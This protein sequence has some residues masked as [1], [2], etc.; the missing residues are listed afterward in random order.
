MK[1]TILIFGVLCLWLRLA[2]GEI[3]STATPEAAWDHSSPPASNFVARYEIHY[4]PIARRTNDP[5]YE[6][7]YTRTNAV[8][9]FFTSAM[10]TNLYPGIWFISAIAVGT[11]GIPSLYTANEIC[12]TNRGPAPGNLRMVGLGP[13]L[14]L[15]GA[16]SAGGPWQDLAQLTNPP[17]ALSL[18]QRQLFRL[19]MSTNLPP[20]PGGVP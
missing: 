10:L 17:V 1:L 11:N 18:Q 4:G 20:F 15:Q 9:R 3:G 19:R 8:V 14:M 13:N 7:G 16:P 5:T 2:S 6:R 12:Y